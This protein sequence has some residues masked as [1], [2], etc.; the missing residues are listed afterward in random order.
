MKILKEL[1]T[2]KGKEIA[3]HAGGGNKAQNERV[4]A[5]NAILAARSVAAAKAASGDKIAARITMHIVGE[6]FPVNAK[7]VDDVF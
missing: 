3:L 2:K 1:R 4:V 6:R 5:L 7:M